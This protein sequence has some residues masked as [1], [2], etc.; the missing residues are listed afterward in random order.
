MMNIMSVATIEEKNTV[1]CAEVLHLLCFYC[2]Y[3]STSLGQQFAFIQ[4]IKTQKMF[5]SVHLL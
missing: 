3:R 5:Y 1:N 4:Y 2:V